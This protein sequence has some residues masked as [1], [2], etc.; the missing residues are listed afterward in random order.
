[1][2]AIDILINSVTVIGCGYVAAMF[3]LGAVKRS[4]VSV[5]IEQV[6]VPDGEFSCGA[7]A[8]DAAI[9]DGYMNRVRMADNVV[10]FVRPVRQHPALD[11]LGIRG[12]KKLASAAKIRGYGRMGKAE[13]IER[14]MTA[15][16]R[17]A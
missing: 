11:G 1:M 5:T 10:P 4:W 8:E 3:V 6:T 17:A 13:L 2:Q 7:S 14:L 9:V 15:V 12:L 16:Q